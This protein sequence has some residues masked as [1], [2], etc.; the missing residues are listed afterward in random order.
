MLQSLQN[1]PRP[2]SGSNTD[3]HSLLFL[4]I[5][6]S[7]K[8]RPVFNTGFWA[9]LRSLE[10]SL[11]TKLLVA[12]VSYGLTGQYSNEAMSEH[13]GLRGSWWWYGWF[14]F[15][16]E[17]MSSNSQHSQKKLGWL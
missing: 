12:C 9:F 10:G 8:M 11:G 15:Q 1:H 14:I 3:L 7:V 16:H 13:W 4:T 2:S 6:M 5:W 17:D